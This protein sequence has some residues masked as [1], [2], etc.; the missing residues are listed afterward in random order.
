MI[1]YKPQLDD[2]RCLYSRGDP[3]RDIEAA[4]IHGVE[5]GKAKC[6]KHGVFTSAK[7]WTIKGKK[8]NYCYAT[9]YIAE[10]PRG[11]WLTA[12]D[13]QVHNS[14]NGSMPGIWNE[15]GW[16]SEARAYLQALCDLIKRCEEY[17]KSRDK[18]ERERAAELKRKLEENYL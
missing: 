9:I 7:A 2:I 17:M 14:Y 13:L 3:R 15:C 4:A 11:H 16:E 18:L 8:P 12:Y 1:D 10:T 5:L 6:N